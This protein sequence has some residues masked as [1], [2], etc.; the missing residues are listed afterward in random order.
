MFLT[1]LCPVVED[2]IRHHVT[3]V[4]NSIDQA[5]LWAAQIT[6]FRDWPSKARRGS[7]ITQY[8]PAGLTL[9]GVD[10]LAENSGS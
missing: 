7:S 9:E 1:D 4:L 10:A 5:E 3:P 6:R 8:V 2:M